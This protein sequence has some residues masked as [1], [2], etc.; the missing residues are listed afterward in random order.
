MCQRVLGEFVGVVAQEMYHMMLC[1]HSMLVVLAPKN[2]N[3]DTRHLNIHLLEHVFHTK[4]C[5]HL[6]VGF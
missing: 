4:K 2:R 3:L 1:S 5:T 6:D